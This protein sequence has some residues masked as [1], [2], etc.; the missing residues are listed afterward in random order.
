MSGWSPNQSRNEPYNKMSSVHLHIVTV[1]SFGTEHCRPYSLRLPSRLNSVGR[2]PLSFALVNSSV[3]V[4]KKET[5][6]LSQSIHSTTQHDLP[7]A[8]RTPSID[9]PRLLRRPNSVVRYPSRL[10]L[11]SV[12]ETTV[13]DPSPHLIPYQSQ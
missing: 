6:P 9:L 2:V 12:M 11:G 3:S 10:F 8:E 13:F 5:V 1:P 4:S 7:K